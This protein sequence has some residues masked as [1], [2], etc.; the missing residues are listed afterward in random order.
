MGFIHLFLDMFRFFIFFSGTL[1]SLAARL[2]MQDEVKV[3]CDMPHEIKAGDTVRVEIMITKGDLTG[4]GALQVELPAGLSMLRFETSGKQ[5]E[6][7]PPLKTWE[8]EALPESSQL[9][10]KLVLLA[11]PDASGSKA[12]TAH[13]FYTEENEKQEVNMIPAEFEILNPAKTAQVSDTTAAGKEPAGN[14]NFV[15]TYSVNAQNEI[16]VNLQIRKGNTR[17]FARYSDAVPA[18]MKVKTQKTDGASFSVADGKLRFV[19]VNVP[20]REELQV[21]YTITAK[22]V[23][24]IKLDGEYSYVEQ[25]QTRR[26]KLPAET[27]NITKTV[28]TVTPAGVTPGSDSTAVNTPTAQASKEKE[29]KPTTGVEFSIQ[30]GAFSKKKV[31]VAQ[32]K[33]KFRVTDALRTE[34]AEGFTKFISGSFAEYKAARDKREEIK[35]NNK[36]K[37]AFVVAYN[38]G[39]RITVQE[40]L[41]INNQKWYK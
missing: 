13:F 6:T 2:F 12:I 22:N 33:K 8:W 3:T 30:L 21:M 7:N 14:I 37:T 28:A 9:P 27:V 15:R 32:M 34:M 5:T 41:M 36:V 19:W 4:F 25:N 1:F 26:F 35:E 23:Q 11:A 18:G 24:E 29:T 16:T 40:A 20:D 38:N 17:G 39:K 10:V 31:T